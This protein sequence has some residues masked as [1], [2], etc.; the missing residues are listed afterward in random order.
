MIHSYSSIYNLGH[1]AI[2]DLLKGPVIVEEKVDGSQ[3]SFRLNEVGELEIRSKGAMLNLAAP[4]GMFKRAVESITERTHL[5][6]RGWTYR[7]EYLKSPHHN[8]LTYSRVPAGNI[9]I[10]D[11]DTGD[12]SYLDYDQKQR[13][14]VELGLEV[15]PRLFSGLVAD[16]N[17]F[18]ALLET[19]SVLGGQKIEGVVIKPFGYDAYGRDKKVL[20][21]KFVSESFREVHGAT[22]KAEHGPKGPGDILAILQSE[23]SSPARWQKALIHLRE[24]GQIQDDPKD[25]GALMKEVPLDIEKECAEELKEKLLAWAWPRLRRA[26]TRGLPEWYKEQLLK[27][28]FEQQ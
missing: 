4:E 24:A 5:L 7:G 27:K 28:Q 18:R 11:V 25:I 3:L 15:V 13:A 9:I 19:E 14:S 17:Q 12:Q 8:C 16:V 2:A 6:K 23:Y 21:G 20:M 10:F 26:V 22:W 1:A